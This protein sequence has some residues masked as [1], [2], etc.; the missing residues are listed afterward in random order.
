MLGVVGTSLTPSPPQTLLLQDF[1]IQL[2]ER[3]MLRLRGEV[4]TEEKQVLEKKAQKL[5]HRLEEKKRTAIM[6]TTQ[7]KKLQVDR[8]LSYCRMFLILFFLM[9]WVFLLFLSP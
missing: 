9:I 3:K 7:L 8:P 5:A 4:N 2:L 1:Q 6:L